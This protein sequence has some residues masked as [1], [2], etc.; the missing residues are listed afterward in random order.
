MRGGMVNKDIEIVDFHEE[1]YKTLIAY[2]EWRV[3]VM[4]F[5]DKLRIENIKS[6]QKHTL[7]DEVFVL[8]SGSC[9]LL[10]GGNGDAPGVVEKVEMQL[11]KMYNVK[12]GVW[13]NH[14]M[15]E[16]GE[17]LIVENRDTSIDNSPILPLTDER[18]RDMMSLF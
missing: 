8:M 13:H 7:T 12:K 16:Q 18:Q 9:T 15:S 2:G 14:I 5:C 1:G 10:L 17:V 11:H 3:A 4:K 6:M